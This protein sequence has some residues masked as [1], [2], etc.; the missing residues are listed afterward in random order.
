[1]FVLLSGRVEQLDAI[2]KM[3]FARVIC[4]GGDAMDAIQLRAFEP[5]SESNPVTP[6]TDELNKHSLDL[7]LWKGD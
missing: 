1:M 7:T 5:V 3:T 4:A 2:R 6:C